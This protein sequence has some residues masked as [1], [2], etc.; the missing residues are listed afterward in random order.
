LNSRY[1]SRLSE[2][3]IFE[4]LA[5]RL[6]SVKS[7]ILNNELN[8]LEEADLTFLD[9]ENNSRYSG[10][11]VFVYKLLETQIDPTLKKYS[12][13]N[14]ASKDLS[15]ARETLNLYM[16]SNAP[17]KGY[18]FFSKPIESSLEELFVLAQKALIELNL[19][20]NQAKK[21]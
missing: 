2:I 4:T 21:V 16:D 17:C 13:L 18:F 9:R 10:V 3:R 12:S 20:A 7:S 11:T 5:N 19:P 14:E 1:S 6:K 15:I 8:V